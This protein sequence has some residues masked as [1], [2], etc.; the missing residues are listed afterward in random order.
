MEPEWVIGPV[1]RTTN[2][3]LA[4]IL[5]LYA[6]GIA[7][8]AG[9]AVVNHLEDRW[10]SVLAS[11]VAAT[12]A[13]WFWADGERLLP[14]PFNVFVVGAAVAGVAIT[15]TFTLGR[16]QVQVDQFQRAAGQ[17][18]N[19]LLE[20]IVPADR[21]QAIRE[22]RKSMEPDKEVFRKTPHLLMG[23]FIAVYL[24]LGYLIL[25][26]LWA[27]LY[28]G[29]PG[30]GE[31]AQ[32]LDAVIRLADAPW[33][34]SG[35]IFSLMALLALLVL[36]APNELLRLRYPELSYPFKQTILRAQRRKE[37]GLFGAH[38]YIV[39]ALPLAIVALTFDGSN[40]PV[41]IPAVVALIAVTIFA[42]AMSALI[43]RRFG[44]TKWFHNSDKTYVGTLAGVVTAFI[45]ALPFVGIPVAFVTAGVFLIIDALAP[46]PAPFTDNILNPIG[47]AIAYVVAEPWIMPLIPFY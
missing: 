46:V 26:G 31:S 12:L 2:W 19:A 27:I 44:R 41:T 13:G 36:L 21:L 40:W 32:N 10:S 25:R 28:G 29:R 35:H 47:L 33:L 42:D 17:R 3:I 20:E 11:I 23:L 24:A 37:E 7:Y 6:I 5:S 14:A 8:N 39:I 34:E 1:S 9:R 30:N 4:G 15:L 43:G 18:M 45:V 16:Y 22:W 38:L